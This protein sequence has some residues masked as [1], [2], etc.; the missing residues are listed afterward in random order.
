MWFEYATQ[1][2]TTTIDPNLPNRQ[3]LFQE[4]STRE[5]RIN[6]RNLREIQRKKDYKT[7]QS[8]ESPDLADS[9][10]LAYYQPPIMPH[11]DVAI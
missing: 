8:T 1:L 3:E 7:E 9:V 6:E 10:L 5:W 4:L 11:W 2:P